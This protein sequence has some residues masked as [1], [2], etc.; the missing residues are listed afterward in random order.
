MSAS[1]PS[2]PLVKILTFQR[3]PKALV[4]S[5]GLSSHQQLRSYE[6]WPQLRDSS[7]ILEDLGIKIR[8]AGHKTSGLSRHHSSYSQVVV[9]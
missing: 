6:T 9:N 2:V 3:R 1:G 5:K 7:D 8:S 4:W